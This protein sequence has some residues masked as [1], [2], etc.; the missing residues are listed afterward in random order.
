VELTY[1]FFGDKDRAAAYFIVY[2][3]FYSK[4]ITEEE[5]QPEMVYGI[6]NNVGSNLPYLL[7]RILGHSF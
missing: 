4:T 1:H 5:L 6:M 7:A 3:K 2:G